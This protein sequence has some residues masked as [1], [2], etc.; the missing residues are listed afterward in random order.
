MVFRLSR[1]TSAE[2]LTARYN[3]IFN[4]VKSHIAKKVHLFATC[5][6]RLQQQTEVLN[7][8]ETLLAGLK[9]VLVA[10]S[11]NMLKK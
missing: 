1:E 5:D 9:D 3:K 6:G 10:E 4:F 2:E 8:R 11:G 7:D